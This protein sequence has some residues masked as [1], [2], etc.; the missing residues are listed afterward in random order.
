MTATDRTA[1][2]D[3]ERLGLRRRLRAASA[4]TAPSYEWRVPA[5]LVVFAG[6]WRLLILALSWLWGQT[7]IATAW[8]PGVNS[9][10]L[11]RYSIRW[12]AGFYLDIARHGYH[13]Q[14]GYSSSIA[15]FP[16]YPLLIRAADVVLPNS[17]T[18]A[19]LVVSQLAL[20]AAVIY[21]FRIAKLDFGR[22]IAWR[23]V[24]LLLAFPS[25]FFFSAVYPEGLLLLGFAGSLYHARRGQWLRA[26]LFGM[27][28]GATKLVGVVAIVPLVFEFWS[29]RALSPR[30][31]GPVLSVAL[32][33]L[34]TIA[35]LG[36]LQARYGDFRVLFETEPTGFAT[37]FS[38]PS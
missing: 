32:A 13:Y 27:L 26:G 7:P 10:W 18:F 6:G 25:A 20:T 15:F 4:A 36:Y 37:R 21:V 16:L 28:S 12:D 34:G 3:L 22:Q 14:P 11:W 29:Q 33:P 19:A 24:V 8:P 9:M 35:Y 23:S 31:P 1:S 5:A 2:I 38:P 30:R 17:E